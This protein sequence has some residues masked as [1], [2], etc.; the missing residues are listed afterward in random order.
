MAKTA[1][2]DLLTAQRAYFLAGHTT[3]DINGKIFRTNA[4]ADLKD[5]LKKY[6]PQL[7]EALY[8]DLGKSEYEAYTTEI[9]PVQQELEE[10]FRHGGGWL[11][12]KKLLPNKL[13]MHGA[14]RVQYDPK[15]CVLIISPWNYPVQLTLVPLIAAILAGNVCVVKP[16]ELAPKT[17]TV[18]AEMINATFAENYIHV[19]TGG[20]DVAKL[21]TAEPFDHIFFTG[22][23]AVG[24]QIMHAAAEHLASVTLELGGKCPCIVTEHANI[25]RAAKAI[26][27]G[28]TLNAGQT[29]VAPDYVLVAEAQKEAFMSSLVFAIREMYGE[30]PI[31]SDDWGRIVNRQ[32]FDRLNAYIEPHRNTTRLF[33]GGQTNEQQLK[34]A[35]TILTNVELN[36]PVMQEEIFGP[37]ITVLTFDKVSN[38]VRFINSRPTPLAAYLFN[39]GG[40]VNTMVSRKLRC[41]GMCI[42][43]TMTHM[44]HPGLPFGGVGMSGVG[45]YHGE[46]GFKEFSNQR[47][48]FRAVSQPNQLRYP[49]YSDAKLLKLKQMFKL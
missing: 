43:D 29:C 33:F 14:G 34:I 35:P 24:K 2:G 22:S 20:P 39:E 49:P 32:H 5:A 38:A 42:N 47:A 9:I 1:Y 7:V 23:P 44:L 25:Y 19:V 27:W 8:M 15:G 4:L 36:D 45:R 3:H 40:E 41:G 21:L 13:T 30:N 12:S 11:K 26:A 16:S 46:A 48:I 6:E 17:A 10:A 37:I 18:L 28:K 31:Q